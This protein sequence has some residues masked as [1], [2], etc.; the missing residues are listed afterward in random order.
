MVVLVVG[1]RV[2]VVVV[3]VGATVV[4][5]VV[6]GSPV[7]VV[8]DVDPGCGVVAG[9]WVVV[10]PDRSGDAANAGVVPRAME[11]MTGVA[12]APVTSTPRT[13]LR[14]SAGTFLKESGFTRKPFGV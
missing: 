2:V 6:T 11:E 12:I 9:C 4:V 1:A 8:V 14:R 7:V 3:V 13:K 5:V 10:G